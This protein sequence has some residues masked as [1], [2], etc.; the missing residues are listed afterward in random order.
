[1]LHDALFSLKLEQRA[2]EPGESCNYH[3]LWGVIILSKILKSGF[4]FQKL[5]FGRTTGFSQLVGNDTF[6]SLGQICGPT[7]GGPPPGERRRL[8]TEGA[9]RG[10]AWLPRGRRG[11]APAPSCRQTEEQ[12][13]QEG[14]Q[15]QGSTSPWRQGQPR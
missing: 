14:L 2:N 7:C 1:M 9:R 4:V 3:K 12:E 5:D 8:C 10:R 15:L 11:C 13:Q 6:P